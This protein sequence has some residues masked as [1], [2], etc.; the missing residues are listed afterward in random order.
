[1]KRG[2]P[3]PHD[4][5]LRVVN[6]LCELDCVR[7]PSR[8]Y[9]FG[10]SVS[11]F[12]EKAIDLPGSD[13]RTDV[14]TLVRLTLRQDSG[15]E[16]LLYAVGL[17]EGEDTAT[18]VR[19]RIFAPAAV[20]RQQVSAVFEHGDVTEVRALL[21]GDLG[22]D[23]RR[24]RDRLARELRRDLPH[25][26]SVVGLFDHLLD[27]NAQPD[28]L[29]PAVVLVEYAAALVPRLSERLR[30]WSEPRAA[31]IGLLEALLRR[32]DQIAAERPQD[33]DIP[34]CL[35][36]MADPAQDGSPDVVVRH[37][38][39]ETAGYWSPL[40]GQEEQ[41]ALAG[42][43]AAVERAILRGEQMWAE[44]ADDDGG[45]VYVEFVL[46]YSLLNH[47]VARLELGSGAH[48][49]MPIGPRYFVH[50]RSLERMRGRDP[51]QLR[52]WRRRWKALRACAAPQSH[53]WQG[54]EGRHL[55]PWRTALMQNEQLTAV[56]LGSPPCE[57]GALEALKAA[58]AEGIGLAVW[59]R[60]DPSQPQVRELLKLLI[61]FAPG[62]IPAKVHQLRAQAE[63]DV[64]GRQL[65]GRHIAL[66]WDDPFRLVDCQEVSA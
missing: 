54:P 19:H 43:S 9:E 21:T 57:G 46:P 64:E 65:L 47:D 39:N 31:E 27:A 58:V 60:R 16:A 6:E 12:M 3:F 42:L 18:V 40:P 36:V 35:V 45:P 13:A 53:H 34:R 22:I 1:M 55:A 14:I 52:R 38:V 29:P 44:A 62:Q 8:R 59:D 28:G 41:V 17:H 30:A 33:Q 32:R 5:R 50:L 49:P 20:E 10:Q 37:W 15:I 63:I 7:D 24:L 2:S 25:Q 61:G 66:L 51:G 26:V 4:L 23:P 11:E 48:D 56:V